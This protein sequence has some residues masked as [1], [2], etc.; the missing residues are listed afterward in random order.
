MKKGA[1]VL[2]AIVTELSWSKGGLGSTVYISLLLVPPHSPLLPL[3][4]RPQLSSFRADVWAGN[5][6]PRF[7]SQITISCY[8]FL[9]SK[10]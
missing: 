6:F 4:R 3:P 8:P 9:Q 7:C 5:N 2:G 10:T 1:A